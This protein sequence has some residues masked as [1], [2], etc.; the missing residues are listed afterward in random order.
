MN[1][2][3]ALS[4]GLGVVVERSR[5]RGKFKVQHFRNDELIGEHDFKNDITNEGLNRI[6]EVMFHSGTQ[7]TT[8]Y[9]GLIDNAGFSAIDPTDTMASHAGWS[10]ATQYTQANRVSWSPGAASGRSITNSTAFQFDINATKTLYGIFITS[11]NTKGGT[12]GVLW[13][14]GAFSSP[15]S[16]VNGDT[17]KVTYTVSG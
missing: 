15:L 16:V 3:M 6:L 8:W 17:V 9:S 2:A 14:T 13:S 5:L 11:N 1:E 7:L 10:E 12:T 4:Q